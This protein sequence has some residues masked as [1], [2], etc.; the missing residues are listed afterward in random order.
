[1]RQ[2]AQQLRCIALVNQKGGCGKTTTAVSLAAGLALYGYK[3]AI[4][5]MDSQCNATASFGLRPDE[6]VDAGRLTVADMLLA[7]RG[8]Q[9]C[10]ID[11]PGRLGG[12]LSIIPGHRGLSSVP[13]RLEAELQ[14]VM[15]SGTQS[16][17][18]A[19]ELRNQHR[20]RLRQSLRT[21][22]GTF[23]VVV[24]DTPPELGFLLTASLL[25]SH[26]YVIPLKPSGYD[27]SGLDSLSRTVRRVKQ[28]LN[29]GITCTGV[30]QT[31]VDGRAN[32]DQQIRQLLIAKFGQDLVFGIGIHSA[33]AHR[34]TTVEG[35]TIFELYPESKAAEQYA[36]FTREVIRRMGLKLRSA[37][38]TEGI[39][40]LLPQPKPKPEQVR[41]AS[42]PSSVGEAVNNG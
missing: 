31:M 34:Q 18:E 20:H 28:S 15:Y 6:I 39:V 11:L 21:L 24:I 42:A 10:L 40:E 3:T 13:Q 8:A 16:D 37:V 35:Q 26:T 25:A 27:L 23:D 14:A 32:L 30:L 4:V 9:D 5:D 17:L 2:E 36:E 19:D 1:M 22:E 29:P 38:D 12:N 7:D 41:G 33:V